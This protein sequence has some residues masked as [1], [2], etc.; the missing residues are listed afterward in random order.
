MPSDKTFSLTYK[1]KLSVRSS[2]KFE[3][4]TFIIIAILGY[5]LVFKLTSYLADFKVLKNY[6]RLDILFLL[7]CL[8]LLFLPMSHI[9]KE[10]KSIE[11]NRELAK[12]YPFIIDDKINYGFGKDF[13]NWFNDRYNFRR[14]YLKLYGW[15]KYYLSKSSCTNNGVLLN[16]QNNWF[17][18][19]KFHKA[20]Q[21]T[22]TSEQLSLYL[23]N[24]KVLNDY[25][26]KNNKK[27]YFMI[28]PEKGMIYKDEIYKG[29]VLNPLPTSD[30]IPEIIKNVSQT[31]G[32]DILYPFEELQQAKQEKLVFYKNDHH[33]NDEGYL[34]VFNSLIKRM[35][36]DGLKFPYLSES[37]FIIKNSNKARSGERFSMGS[38]FCT[39]NVDNESLL[40]ESYKF[41]T[42]KRDR[43]LNKKVL[44]I[45]DSYVNMTK[46]FFTSIFQTSNSIFVRGLAPLARKSVI[47]NN[48]KL[49]ND[50][51][52]VVVIFSAI[53]P[54][55]LLDMDF[56]I[57]KNVGSDK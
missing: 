33:L 35:N 53:Q 14:N 30:P 19:L 55:L 21:K 57:L 44:V 38:G 52:V 54:E 28:I 2:I 4:L 5:L 12:W 16:K 17:L 10:I 40:N 22:F 25:C 7:V 43:V 36:D 49:L 41:Y 48:L 51:D 3:V 18:I 29:L 42:A 15:I 26:N 46:Q 8:I 20:A 27:L 37:D 31:S 32:V 23:N 47:K 39:L 13:E 1:D 50:A 6:S 9:S 56:E 45:G 24:I 34:V 11:E